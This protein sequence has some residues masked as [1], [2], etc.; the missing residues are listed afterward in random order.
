MTQRER[1]RW[2][3]LFKALGFIIARSFSGNDAKTLVD[4][5]NK[6]ADETIKWLLP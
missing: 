3:L 1:Y 5:L 4:E 6:E 2:F